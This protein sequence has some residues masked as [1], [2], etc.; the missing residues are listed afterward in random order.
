MNQTTLTFGEYSVLV[1]T[2]N[3][4]ARTIALEI[5]GFT[6]EGSS[7]TEEELIASGFLLVDLQDCQDELDKETRNRNLP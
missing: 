3:D 1:A 2:E 5:L 6:L 7:V 4:G